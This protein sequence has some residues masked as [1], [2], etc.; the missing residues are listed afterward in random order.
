MKRLEALRRI[1]ESPALNLG[2]GLILCGSG[3]AETVREL[4]EL[5][6]WRL[7]AHHGVVA[8]GLV[9]VLKSIPDLL[10]GLEY[11]VRGEGG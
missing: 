3:L 4:S 9:T 10:E 6:E 8:F 7:G 2:A 11:V 1:T 5:G